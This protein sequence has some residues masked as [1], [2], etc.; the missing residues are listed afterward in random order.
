MDLRDSAVLHYPRTS[1]VKRRRTIW[2]RIHL[3]PW[4]DRKSVV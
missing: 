2:S 1:S 4:L 3:D